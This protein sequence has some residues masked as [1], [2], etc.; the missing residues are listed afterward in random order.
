MVTTATSCEFNGDVVINEDEDVHLKRLAILLVDDAIR[1]EC[2]VTKSGFCYSASGTVAADLEAGVENGS[3]KIDWEAKDPDVDVDI[4]WECY[5]V[6]IA[7][8][9]ITGGIIGI[10]VGTGFPASSGP[11]RVG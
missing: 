3:L 6:A 11:W 4:P 1:V 7:V 5:L 8:G 9:A 10:L 2:K